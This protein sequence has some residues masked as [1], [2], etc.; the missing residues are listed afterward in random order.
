MC[1]II[2]TL[3]LVNIVCLYFGIGQSHKLLGVFMTFYAKSVG[4]VLT[5]NM[6]IY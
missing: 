4:G 3:A 2:R 5:K 1:T 6:I